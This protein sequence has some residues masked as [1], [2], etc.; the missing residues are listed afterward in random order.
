MANRMKEDEKNERIIRGLL[1]LPAN[2][3]CINCNSLGPQYVCTNF[4]TFICTNCSGI[5]RE[6]T[7]RVK[8]VSMA[9]FTSQEVNALQEGGNER[10]KEIYFK[11]WDPQR[12]SFPDSSNVDRL[13]DFLKHVYVDRRYTGERSVDRPPRV[14]GEKED[15]YENRRPDTYRGGSRSP[16]YDEAYDRHYVERPGS[17]G[18]NDDKNSRSSYEERRSPGYDQGDYRRSPG[19]FDTVDER[20]R[21][22]RYGNGNQ[23]RRFEDRRLPDG[24]PRPEGRSVNNQK[25]S[26][27]SS[28]PMV[29]PVRE[30]LGE[31]APPLRVG[32]PPRSNG[33]RVA[34]GPAQAQRTTSSNSL[35][36]TDSNPVELK[37]VNSG[38]LIDF[39]ADPEPPVAA[40]PQPPAPQPINSPANGGDWASFDSVPQQKAPQAVSNLSTLESALAELS[41]P[42]APPLSTVSTL[43]NSTAIHFSLTNDAGQGP[44]RQQNQPS[45]FPATQIQSTVMQSTMQPFSPPS[46]VSPSSQPWASSFTPNVQ[47]PLTTPSGQPSQT[48][49]K[50]PA[51][52]SVG[53]S[54]Q[55]PVEVKPSGRRELPPGLFTA[56]Y[57]PASLPGWQTGPHLMGYGM[58]YPRAVFPSM[59]SLQGAL[60]GM[61]NPSTLIRSSSFGASPSPRWVA[62]QQPS[63][64]PALPPSAFM[65]QQAPSNI[66]QVP[67]SL[68]PLGHQQ[69]GGLGGPAFGVSSTDP[70][71]TA[72]YSQ[73][74]TPSFP[75]VGG[76]PFG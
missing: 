53:V 75:P 61:P 63:Y 72:G 48:P 35:A 25:E 30:I 74:G 51:E 19:R 66:S 10:A 41:V 13:R 29:R 36:S 52:T 38:S 57:S 70:H 28:P 9:K 58:Q 46:V 73:P 26:E 44:I 49:L 16:S 71:L 65:V 33:T 67:G 42:V 68:L 69:L 47:V 14:K 56:T 11:E 62:P 6:F 31:D 64:P 22:D 18:R 50:S 37:R 17:G 20:G 60:P 24:V 8:S 3:R 40:A 15:S 59:T 34:D 45:L 5:H 2:R 76:N 7:H 43:P 4:W 23:N 1:K 12:H 54:S 55:P 21:D 32:E 39:N 27:M